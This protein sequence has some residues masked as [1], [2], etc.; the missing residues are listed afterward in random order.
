MILKPALNHSDV[1]V[2]QKYLKANEDEVVATMLGCD[3]TRKHRAVLILEN[4]QVRRSSTAA[5]WFV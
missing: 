1:S 3:L 4:G 5:A 2:T